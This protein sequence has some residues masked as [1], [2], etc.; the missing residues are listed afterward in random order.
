MEYVIPKIQIKDKKNT[1][2]FN[3]LLNMKNKLK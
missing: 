1:I 2:Y 3:I